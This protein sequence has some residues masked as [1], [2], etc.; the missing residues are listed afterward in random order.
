MTEADLAYIQI[1]GITLP[2]ATV[3]RQRPVG[4]GKIPEKIL[5]HHFGKKKKKN[6][7][8]LDVCIHFLI[9]GKGRPV[10]VIWYQKKIKG[11][12]FP[13]SRGWLS[14]IEKDLVR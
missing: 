11:I 12:Q 7:H 14:V 6:C 13:S 10:A 1:R 9:N 3:S 5:N 2:G 4:S 8:T